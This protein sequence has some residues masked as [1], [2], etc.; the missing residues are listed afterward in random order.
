MLVVLG[1]FMLGGW[2]L[3]RWK[4]KAPFRKPATIKSGL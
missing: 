4:K 2:L 1:V 3:R